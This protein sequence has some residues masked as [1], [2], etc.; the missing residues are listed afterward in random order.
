MLSL[1]LASACGVYPVTH[2]SRHTV[3]NDTAGLIIRRPSPVP[4]SPT[5]PLQSSSAQLLLHSARAELLVH[6]HRFSKIC[7][8]CFAKRFTDEGTSG[9]PSGID[10]VP[11]RPS[12]TTSSFWTKYEKSRELSSRYFGLKGC[13][14]AMSQ[15]SRWLKNS[16]KVFHSSNP[17]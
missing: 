10:N 2:P 13:L 16:S 8:S 12:I 14:L 7:C 15:T 3:I 5:A 4:I 6:S 1:R 17:Y 11:E 9:R